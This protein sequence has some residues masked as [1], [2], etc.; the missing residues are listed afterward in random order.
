MVHSIVRSFYL[1]KCVGR[2]VHCLSTESEMKI[3]TK[4]IRDRSDSAGK[5]GTD[6]LIV[7]RMLVVHATWSA[8]SCR[9]FT[10]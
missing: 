1:Q 5:R 2:F 9:D 7:D 3:D 8:L 6:Q 10:F 4:T